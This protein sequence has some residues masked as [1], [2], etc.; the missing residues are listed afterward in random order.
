VRRE[1]KRV[2]EVR[3]ECPRLGLSLVLPEGMCFKLSFTTRW[4]GWSCSWLV[5]GRR[6]E[7]GLG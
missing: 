5:P 7:E 6:G 3:G 4:D 1:E 2:R